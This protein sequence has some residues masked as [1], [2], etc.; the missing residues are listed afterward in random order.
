MMN[1]ELTIIIIRHIIIPHSVY[2]SYRV[3]TLIHIILNTAG[4]L[5]QHQL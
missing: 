3:V 5:G 1:W 4:Q 2:N